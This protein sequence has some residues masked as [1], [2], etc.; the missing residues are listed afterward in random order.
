M[1]DP[2]RPGDRPLAVWLVIS[3][4]DDAVLWV[5]ADRLRTAGPHLELVVDIAFLGRPRTVVERRLVEQRVIVC[6]P[7]DHPAAWRPHRW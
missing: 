3:R 6:E 7:I 1:P 2:M 5:E 4:P